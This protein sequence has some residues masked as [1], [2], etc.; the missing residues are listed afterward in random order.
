MSDKKVSEMTANSTPQSTDL[1][2]LIDDPSG[3]PTNQKITV[4]DL[5]PIGDIHTWGAVGD[6][7]TD[8]SAAFR[9]ADAAGVTVITL[10]PNKNY[11]VSADGANSYAI[12][13][14]ANNGLKIVG[15]GS[16]ITSTDGGLQLIR[17][18]GTGH[19]I[20]TDLNLVGPAT[21]GTDLAAGLLQINS[22]TGVSLTNVKTSGSDQDGIAVS[23]CTKVRLIGCE[24]SNDS[25]AGIYVN[26]S[27]DVRI[28]ACD[29]DSFGGHTTSGNIVGTGIQ[30]SGNTKLVCIGNTIKNGVGTGIRCNDVNS[31]HPSENV[32]IGN[33]VSGCRNATNE[34]ESIGIRCTN[35]D[36]TTLCGTVVH[37]NDVF[38]CGQ[39]GINIENHDGFSC[40]GN[41]VVQIDESGIVIGT[42][43]DGVVQNNDVWNCDTDGDTG[44]FCIQTIN[45]AD[46]VV[47]KGN[48][49]KNS[50]EYTSG[51]A[52]LRA[53]DGGSGTN[54]VQNVT[55]AL[56]DTG[57]PSIL[58]GGLF[59]T[60]GTTAI[61]DFDDGVIGDEITILASHTVT[62][63]D[64]AQLILAG[65]ANY[66]MT[67]SDTLT[68]KMFDNQVWQ[69]TS[70]SVN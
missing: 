25:K 41:R 4:A 34:N 64:G 23:A 32:I 53:S 26:Q 59:D 66:G 46:G 19:F 24:S 57:T 67:D 16:T 62:I 60:G 43:T 9:A 28:V 3:S 51:S 7:S 8:D 30:L 61:T 20:A 55:R 48:N 31:I 37:D 39:W 14:S 13:H 69:E 5:I 1:L 47:I 29:V 65:G 44:L 27:T 52:N 17:N 10:R 12:L 15:N 68:L 49:F 11:I 40:K 54:V 21:D 2:M 50:S 33:L 35:G 38:D 6:G 70:R 56:D 45:A 42:V 18:T 63:T 22:A 36:V 58:G